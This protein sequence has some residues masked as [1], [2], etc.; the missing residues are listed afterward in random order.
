MKE[1]RKYDWLNRSN[2]LLGGLLIILGGLFLLGEL[3]DI[4]IA[5][6]I[7]PFF[8]IVAGVLMF[9]GALALDD[10]VGMALAMVSGIVTMVGAILAFQNLTDTWAS[11]AYAWALVAP[12]SLGMGQ[13]LYG[14]VK[15]RPELVKSGKDVTK[16]GLGMFVVAAV[17]FEFII[18]INGH[19]MGRFGWPLLLIAFGFFL[20]IRNLWANRQQT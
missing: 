9:I 15:N 16:V 14:A 8:I 19:G 7:W 17:F 11:W 2:A 10:E 18:G 6:V 20:L 4:H 13:W 5:H 12:T 1:K 3:F